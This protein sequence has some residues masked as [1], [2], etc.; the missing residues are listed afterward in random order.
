MADRIA[1]G[2]RWLATEIS[3]TREQFRIAQGEDGDELLDGLVS[4]GY[5]RQGQGRYQASDA[6]FARLDAQP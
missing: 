6:G 5:V 1:D 2:L 4:Q 3:A